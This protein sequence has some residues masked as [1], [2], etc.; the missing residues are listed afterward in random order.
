MLHVLVGNAFT[1]LF[2]VACGLAALLALERGDRRGD[3]AACA[4]LCLGV[5]T[6]TVALAFLAGAIASV[7]L[8]G[9][10]RRRAWVVALPLGTYA[11]WLI[12]A[13]Q[14]STGPG[15]Q[16]EL[17]DIL[18]LP[19]WGAQSLSAVLG[20]LSGFDY[21][22]PGSSS[23]A[24][25]GPPLAVLALVGFGWRMRRG[26][27]P[28]TLWVALAVLLALWGLGVLASAGNRPPDSARYLFP[29]AVV[30]LMAAAACAGGSR[31]S[32]SALV[33][34]FAVAASG[35]AVNA[36][37]L[38]DAGAMLRS[39]YAVQVRAAFAALDLAGDRARRRFDPPSIPNDE[40]AIVGSQSPLTF[41][42]KTV[43][44][45]GG[46]GVAGYLR[47]RR[48]Y[49][50]LGYSLGELRAAE[51]K[52]RGQTDSVLVAALGLRLSPVPAAAGT[53]CR[54]VEAG[55]DG[56]AR[57]E[58]SHGGAVLESARGGAVE[59]QRF[60]EESWSRVGTLAAGQPAEL[61]VPA[62]RAADPWRISVQAPFLR[63]CEIS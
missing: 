53:A 45:F 61:A 10:R 43:D 60:A 4:L 1:V 47:A 44:E 18:L 30:V 31:W 8:G 55:G 48:D 15:G 20:A 26:A 29:G 38:K 27:I 54:R 63:V 36:V 11:A 3:L 57:A 25:F 23:V 5:V 22:F 41:P 9:D 39:A 50:A 32:R 33:A 19:S 52:V 17:T 62:D 51:D 6:Y 13:S 2:A 42:F 58:L 21:S 40:G 56:D 12:W 14:F 35:L 37:L 49:G 59:V 7:A 46:V 34:L 24:Q 16:T 28:S